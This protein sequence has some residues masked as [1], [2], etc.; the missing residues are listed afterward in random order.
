MLQQLCLTRHSSNYN[1]SLSYTSL[2]HTSAAIITL[3][4]PTLLCLTRHSS[5]YNISLSYTSLSHMLKQLC[6]TCCCSNNNISL[7]PT[8]FCFTCHS[9]VQQFSPTHLCLTCHSAVQHQ[10]FSHAY[11]TAAYN[12]S[13]SRTLPWLISQQR[14]TTVPLL[15]SSVSHRHSIIQLQ[16]LSNTSLTHLTAA[17]NIS[18]SPTLLHFS[19][20]HRPSIIQLQH[21]FHTSLVLHFSCFTCH[22]SIKHCV[23]LTLFL[24]HSSR[25]H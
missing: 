17:C 11:I 5:S 18:V 16:C 6:L 8:L 23:C 24:F 14:V 1:I 25:E 2:S 3:V 9:S 21:F 20:S 15:H 4:S 7:C 19:V 22:C 13:V 12:I 10:C